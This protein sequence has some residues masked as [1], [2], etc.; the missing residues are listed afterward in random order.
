M[1]ASPAQVVLALLSA[2]GLIS[3]GWAGSVGSQPSSPDDFVTVYD[4]GANDDGRLMDGPRVVH[5]TVQVRVRS[6]AYPDG[7][8]KG[9]A[10]EAVLDSVNHRT[11]TVG[12]EVVT[13]KVVTVYIPLVHIG[14]EEKNR[15]ELFVVNARL[16]F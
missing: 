14:A 5:P 7:W 10:V 9:R 2:E 1:T 12:S 16:T 6:K 13:I 15:R 8:A 11:L 3:S 4:T